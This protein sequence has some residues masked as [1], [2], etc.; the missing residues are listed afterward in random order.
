MTPEA[1]ALEHATHIVGIRGYSL[2]RRVVIVATL[3]C[4]GSLAVGYAALHIAECQRQQIRLLTTLHNQ[5]KVMDALILTGV[6]VLTQGPGPI[7]AGY[8][9]LLSTVNVIEFMLAEFHV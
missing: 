5:S 7:T 4:W 9:P 2:R 3:L 6:L 8:A 1:P